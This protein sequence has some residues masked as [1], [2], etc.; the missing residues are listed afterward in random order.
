MLPVMIAPDN[1]VFITN[2]LICNVVLELA[3]E[4]SVEL[5]A[6]DKLSELLLP[7][8]SLVLPQEVKMTPKRMMKII[9]INFFIFFCI[10]LIFSN[11]NGAVTVGSVR[12]GIEGYSIVPSYC[13]SGT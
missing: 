13:N 8:E 11:C 6:F 2:G 5:D 12:Q 4:S 7:S 3:S 10:S 9:Y 1:A